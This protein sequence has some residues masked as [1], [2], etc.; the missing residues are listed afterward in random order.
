MKNYVILKMICKKMF[1]GGYG[2]FWYEEGPNS[3]GNDSTILYWLYTRIVFGAY[4]VMAILELL[5]AFCGDFPDEQKADAM[6]LS[7]ELP[8][9]NGYET[10]IY[11][12]IV[13]TYAASV[14]ITLILFLVE[15]FR[16][17]FQGSYYVT[18]ITYYP[19]AEDNDPLAN[20]IR[21][22]FTVIFVSFVE[23]MVT[24]LDGLTV[25]HLIMYRYKFITL[26]NYFNTLRDDV[27]RIKDSG[28]CILAAEKL[29]SGL[30]EGIVMHKELL[31]L[32]LDLD[33]VFGTI[34][35]LQLFLCSGTAVAI[36]LQIAL[37]DS[38]SF[39]G[40]IKMVIFVTA[41]AM[42]LGLSLCNAGEI[43]YEASLL[44]DSIFYCGWY[45]VPP[46]PSPRTNHSKL[47]LVALMQAQRPLVMKAFKMI[48][49]TYATYLE[50]GRMTYSIFALFYAQ[51]SQ[52]K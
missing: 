24:G 50:V 12:L 30:I 38:L 28:N 19:R 3:V 17:V 23:N 1:L 7:H 44:S 18:V 45:E 11:K 39:V 14:F 51:N 42:L 4:G 49:L 13:I 20:F 25:T 35:A 8:A 6:A 46:L 9:S 21:I 37:S 48:E 41:I 47:V 2:N 15:G 29:T 40:V 52:T 36:M 31:R 33:D 32:I 43:L 16:R 5:A 34:T 26:R 10:E 27:L 22:L